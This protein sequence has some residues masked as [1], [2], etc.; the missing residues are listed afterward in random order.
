MSSISGT[1]E[2]PWMF[3]LSDTFTS[4]VSPPVIVSGTLKLNAVFRIV[5]YPSPGALANGFTVF[6]PDLVFPSIEPWILV[7]FFSPAATASG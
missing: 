3:T 4:N 7:I 1:C 5:S 2:I 6:I